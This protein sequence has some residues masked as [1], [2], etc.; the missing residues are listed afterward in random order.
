MRFQSL[1][2]LQFLLKWRKLMTTLFFLIYNLQKESE[3][4]KM[5]N[6]KERE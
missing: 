5:Y 2:I 4:E 6:E 1:K 3:M